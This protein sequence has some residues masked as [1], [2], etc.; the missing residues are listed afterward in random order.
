[1][2]SVRRY[3]WFVAYVT[4]YAAFVLPMKLVIHR[5]KCHKSAEIAVEVCSNS[6]IP[7]LIFV[8]VVGRN[9]TF[10]TFVYLI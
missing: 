6:L 3:I 9:G 7:K 5:V 2:W 8:V 10:G 1:M 4:N